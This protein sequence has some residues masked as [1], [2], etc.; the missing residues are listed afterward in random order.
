MKQLF[1]F[2]DGLGL[3]PPAD[4]N[5]V[6]PEVCPAVCGLIGSRSVPLDACLGVP[7]LPQS[8]TGQAT[9]FCGRNA[10]AF[11]GRHVTGFPGPT[12]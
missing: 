10:A 4:D 5:P 7:G 12:L 6:R 8:A 11:M 2:V 3:A 9:L 1:I